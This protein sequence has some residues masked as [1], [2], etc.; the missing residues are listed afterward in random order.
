[1]TPD[2]TLLVIDDEPLVSA[3]VERFARSFGFNV[4]GRTDARAALA[5][6]PTLKPTAVM[7]DLRMPEINGLEV[8]R[9]IRD[10]DPT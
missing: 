9:A 4:V 3:T 1:M 6:L 10:I 2:A 8:L 7:V 5:E